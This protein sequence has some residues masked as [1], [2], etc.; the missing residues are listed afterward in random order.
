MFSFESHKIHLLALLGP[1]I[2]PNDRF[3]YSVV[4]FNGKIP[5]LSYTLS[6]KKVPLSVGAQPHKGH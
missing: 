3:P 1:F 4:S 5:T 2:D 6:L